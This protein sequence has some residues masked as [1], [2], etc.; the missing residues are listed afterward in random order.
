[1]P[2]RRRIL[3]AVAIVVSVLAVVVIVWLVWFSS[4]FAVAAVRVVGVTG[5]QEAAVLSAASIPV[6]VPLA[7]VDADGAQAAVLRVPWVA[8]AEIRRG[9]PNEVVIAVSPRTPIA[10][11]MTSRRGVDATGA[12]F[13]TAE[14]MRPT[15][16]KV[17]ASGVGLVTAM[18][19]LAG[20]PADLAGRVESLSATTRDDLDLVLRSGAKVHWGSAEQ[21]EFKATVLR[22]LLKRKKDVYDVTAPELPTTFAAN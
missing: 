21:G 20:L 2:R 8:S 6:G 16:P 12:I 15:M 9:W 11:D 14:P 3:R 13:D 18:A 7:R 5:K 19:V 17:K 4:V 10:V 22:A 1:M